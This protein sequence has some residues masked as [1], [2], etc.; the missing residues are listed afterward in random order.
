MDRDA[1]DEFVNW[2]ENNSARLATI[3]D[4]MLGAFGGADDGSRQAMK[5]F[6]KLAKEISPRLTQVQDGLIFEVGPGT[7]KKHGLIL[8]AGGVSE[9]IPAVRHLS[10]ALHEVPDWDV[11]AFKPARAVDPSSQQ[12]VMTS[13]GEKRVTPSEILVSLHPGLTNVGTR[14]YFNG[15]KEEDYQAW[16]QIGFNFLDC[17]LGEYVVMESVGE[18]SF[19]SREEAPSDAFPVSSLKSKFDEAVSTVRSRYTELAQT[20][21]RSRLEQ[22]L[23]L[24]AQDVETLNESIEGSSEEELSINVS[25]WADNAEAAVALQN[26]FGNFDVSSTPKLSAVGSGFDVALSGVVQRKGFSLREWLTQTVGGVKEFVVLTDVHEPEPVNPMLALYAAARLIQSKRFDEAIKILKSALRGVGEHE[27]GQL[28]SLLG[29]AYLEAGKNHEAAEILEKAL[30]LAQDD[31][32][33]GEILTNK[34]SA[35]QRSGN[36]DEAFVCFE[37]ALKLDEGS[38]TRQ[39]NVGQALAQKGRVDEACAH[40]GRA[41]KANP[42]LMEHMLSDLDLKQIRETDQFKAMIQASTK[43]GFLGG[44]FKRK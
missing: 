16:G 44:L 34:G 2:F 3:H 12:I 27:D 4:E 40:L 5:S 18:I 14:L 11:I 39:Y 6:Q 33:R 32:A 26:V 10:E 8:S 19:H 22:S 25:F 43:P 36:P 31:E 41:L 28:H 30:A 35:L 7:T 29:I 38:S 1:A 42:D 9:L 13:D 21:Q 15:Y 23:S 24:I 17:C 20:D 37:E